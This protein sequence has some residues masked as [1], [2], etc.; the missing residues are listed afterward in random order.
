MKK[1]LTG[2]SLVELILA[3]LILAI[4]IP[5]TMIILGGMA[6][7]STDAERQTLAFS[8]AKMRMEQILSKRFSEDNDVGGCTFQSEAFFGPEWETENT[9]DDVDDFVTVRGANNP[10]PGFDGEIEATD[11]LA[12]RG[13]RTNVE[14]WFVTPDEGLF[15]YL[16]HCVTPPCVSTCFKRITVEVVDSRTNQRLARVRSVATPL[17]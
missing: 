3:M 13:F 12:G 10:G 9:F 4:A 11:P 17:K 16:R 1:G 15:G 7:Q 2:F 8:Y 5:G 14:V 6:R